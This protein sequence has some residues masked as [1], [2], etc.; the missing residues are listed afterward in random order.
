MYKIIKKYKSVIIVF[1]LALFIFYSFIPPRKVDA[2]VAETVAVS[3]GVVVSTGSIVALVGST[4]VA[5]GVLLDST[6][7]DGKICKYIVDELISTGTAINSFGVKTV[8]GGKQFLTWTSEGVNNFISTLDLVRSKG[9][10]Y[11]KIYVDAGF[12]P[13]VKGSILTFYLKGSYWTEHTVKYNYPYVINAKKYS[14]YPDFGG[15]SYYTSSTGVF[16]STICGSS[17]GGITYTYSNASGESVCAELDNKYSVPIA[18]DVIGSSVTNGNSVS[19]QPSIGMPLTPSIDNTGVLDSSLSMPYGKTWGDIAADMTIPQSTVV[20]TDTDTV[21]DTSGTIADGLLNIPILG[22]ILKAL[23]DILAFLKGLIENLINALKELL[24]SLF[25]PS[26]TFFN[27]NFNNLK[28]I[29]TSKI[30]Y[31]QYIDVF[32]NNTGGNALKDLTINWNGNTIVVVKLTMFEKFRSLFNSL[33]YGFMFLGL[34][35]YNYNQIYKIFR[36]NNYAKMS[37]TIDRIGK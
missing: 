32:K 26:D 36:N 37:Q 24:I 33:V 29:L 17:G 31:Q 13:C 6:A 9:V 28:D 14:G 19:Y 12:I 11:D 8:E 7:N 34:A 16:D 18:D 23:L 35:I 21:T 27:N 2:V 10:P 4:L 3:G 5:S 1:C 22:T 30:G 25:V 20:D 15:F